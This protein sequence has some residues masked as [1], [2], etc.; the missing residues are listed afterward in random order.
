MTGFV[1]DDDL[2]RLY[3]S[4][5]TVFFPSLYRGSGCRCWR[6]AGAARG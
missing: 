6:P 5:D 2:V 3:Q 1:S 4:A